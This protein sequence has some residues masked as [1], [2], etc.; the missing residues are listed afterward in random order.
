MTRPSE[1]TLETAGAAAAQAAIA[2]TAAR[3]SNSALLRQIFALAAPTTALS[4]LQVIAQLTETWL[5]ARQGTAT[6]AGWAVMLPFVLLMAMMSTGAMGG[7]VV[8]AVAR[9][10]GGK[11][12]DEAAAL[13]QHALMIATGFGLLFAVGVSLLA[14]P[15]ITAVAGADAAVQGAPFAYWVFAAGAVPSWWSNT[16]ASVLRGGGRH[17]LAARV[18]AISSIAMPPLAWALAEPAGLGLP[19]VGLAFALTNTAAAAALAVAVKRGDAGFVPHLALKPS[20]PMFQRILAVGAVASVLA[21]IANLATIGVTAQLRHFGPATVAA[22]GIAA[23]LE[24]LIIPIAFGIGAALTALCGRF[25]GAGD[26]PTARRIA[27]L[28]GLVSLG[29]TGV[30]GITVAL[31]PL[32]FAALFT[33]DAVVAQIAA[34]ALHYTG[35]AFGGF[36]LG[37]SM[38]FAAL[39]AGRL[40]WPVIAGISRLGI[41]VLGGWWLSEG[42]G[43]GAEGN[44][45]AVAL[46]ITSYGVFAAAGVRA[47]VWCGRG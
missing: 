12:R 29:V 18:L 46:A 25:V 24:F 6:L 40:R 30:I 42:L 31:L 17:G 14:R 9:A 5:A 23:R 7:G 26:W 10:L 41:A 20:W 32:H 27:W 37:M 21:T 38:Y 13:V 16:L 44:F 33:S 47:S 19:G 22:Y 15:L 36:G 28:G 8:S 43:L 3:P 35:Y 45:I 11:R 1:N 34:G 39:G 2:T 4:M